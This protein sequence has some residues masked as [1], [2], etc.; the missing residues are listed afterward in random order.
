LGCFASAKYSRFLGVVGSYQKTL[1]TASGVVGTALPVAH[2]LTMAADVAF[3]MN[4]MSVCSYGV[5]AIKGYDSGNGYILEQEDFSIILA[6]WSGSEDVNDAVAYKTMAEIG[7][8]GVKVASKTLAKMVAEKAGIF[9]GKKLAGKFGAEIGAKFSVKL[10]GKAF[11][12]FLPFVGPAVSGGV[13][14]YFINGIAEA[15]KD[16][17][18]LKLK[19]R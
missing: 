17:Y 7:S 13:N 19:N 10:G 18:S 3:L 4:R 12:G 15:A 1:A 14:L 5:G 16:W 9:V 8:I 11:A 6:R 2:L